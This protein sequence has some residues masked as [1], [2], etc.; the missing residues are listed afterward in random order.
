MKKSHRIIS[1]VSALAIGASALAA[2]PS[3]AD[4]YSD[5]FEDVSEIYGD[6]DLDGEVTINDVLAILCYIVRPSDSGTVEQKSM[7]RNSDV[8]Q[9]GDGVNVLDAMFVQKYLVSMVN[10][11]PNGFE[12]TVSQR[13]GN[14]VQRKPVGQFK[15]DNEFVSA[16]MRFAVELFKQCNCDENAL[17]SPTSVMYALTM[18]ANGAGGETLEQMKDVLGAGMDMDRLNKYLASYASV[19]ETEENAYVD[20]NNSLWLNNQME[21]YIPKQSFLDTNVGYH[22]AEIYSVPFDDSGVSEINRWVSDNTR[23]MIPSIIESL[24]PES[25]MCLINT[26]Y[27]ESKWA[28]PYEEYSVHDGKFTLKDGT[29]QDAQMMSSCEREYFELPNATGFSKDYK[30]RKYK[31]VAFL[32]NEGVSVDEFVDSLDETELLRSLSSP[33]YPDELHTKMPKFKLDYGTSLKE[34]LKSMGMPFAFDPSLADFSE[35]YDK[36]AAISDVIHKTAIDVNE[37]GT[38]AAAATAVIMAG[39]ACPPEFVE[40]KYVYLDRPFV[41]MIVDSSTNLPLFMGKLDK[42]AE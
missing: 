6:A 4:L 17:V 14:D 3:S 23:G 24:S 31:F 41:Y 26:L 13:I 15:K 29:E 39:T 19:V 9:I 1:A 34:V 37:D 42:L 18:C 16:Q 22:D 5:P 40:I 36:D 2:V 38:S 32:P 20:L 28:S 21:D 8:Y 30:N 35:M 12:P 27:F 7:L 10:K 33:S 25:V 11:L